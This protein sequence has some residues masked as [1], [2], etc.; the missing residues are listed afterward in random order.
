MGD[1]QQFLN[2][3]FVMRRAFFGP[4]EVA[5]LHE[6]IRTCRPRYPSRLDKKGLTFR[7]HLYFHSPFLQSFI[8]QKKVVDLLK[9]FAGP[10]FWV[11]KDQ[12]VLKAPGGVEFPWH[13]DNGYNGLKD[14]YFQFWVAITEMK[15]AN[16]GL[17]VIPGS[18]RR[19]LLP[20]RLE[21][22]HAV[23]TGGDDA[24]EKPV[25][26]DAKPGDM[27]VF[28]SLLL[29][30][31]GPNHTHTDRVAYVVEFM[32]ANDYDP[33]VRPP[34]FMIAEKGRPSPRFVRFYP[35]N[36]S[37][38]NQAK[39]GLPRLQKGAGKIYGKLYHAVKGPSKK[40]RP[41]SGGA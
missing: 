34:Y 1:R 32:S 37:P 12:A 9:Q 18:H 28:S 21:D 22:T 3:G 8:C 19:G 6:E 33:Y 25:H 4:E 15:P 23:W 36:L 26:I 5:R 30:R 17:W 31:T 39:Y 24:K 7:Q 11:R 35:G 38:A 10:S 14:P 16:G 20:H 13:Q 40:R 41:V 29:H 27:L 2:E